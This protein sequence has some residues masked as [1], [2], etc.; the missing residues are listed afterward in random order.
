MSSSSSYR[1]PLPDEEEMKIELERNE[2]EVKQYLETE[3]RRAES[4]CGDPVRLAYIRSRHKE[5]IQLYDLYKE[6]PEQMHASMQ[7]LIRMVRES[8]NH[9]EHTQRIYRSHVASFIY[10]FLNKAAD[11]EEILRTPSPVIFPYNRQG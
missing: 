3:L 1:P 6:K 8:R 4:D 10:R 9:A 7:Q 11:R 2:Q 5:I